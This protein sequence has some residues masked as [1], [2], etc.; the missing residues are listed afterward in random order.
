MGRRGFV[1]SDLFCDT[2]STLLNVLR[3]RREKENSYT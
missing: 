1:L 3:K 2:V